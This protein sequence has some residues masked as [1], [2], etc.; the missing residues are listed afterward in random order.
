MA[1][2]F[3]G[4]AAELDVAGVPQGAELLARRVQVVEEAAHAGV[5]GVAGP[6]GAQVADGLT[7]EGGGGGLV[8][9]GA[10]GG[11]GE[12][13]GHDVALVGWYGGEV[14]DEGGGHGVP[15]EHGI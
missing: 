8:V 13:A 1:Q 11:I 7:S 6:G 10:D 3:A 2:A 12:E 5:V 4:R 14:A 9:A 15:G